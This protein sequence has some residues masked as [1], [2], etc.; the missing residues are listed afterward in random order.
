M[1]RDI[2]KQLAS[3]KQ[4]FSRKPLALKGARMRIKMKKMIYFGLMV[5]VMVFGFGISAAEETLKTD[6]T[7]DRV[8][9][10]T[11]ATEQT[12]GAAE[13]ILMARLNIKIEYTRAVCNHLAKL[14]R[15]SGPANREGICVYFTPETC[16][17]NFK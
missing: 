2:Y 14:C 7:I 1:K 4:S 15:D 8:A 17:N 13:E 6:N 9:Q 11:L 16:P 3:W 10:Q 12:S 5:W